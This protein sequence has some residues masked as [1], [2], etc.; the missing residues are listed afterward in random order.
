MDLSKFDTSKKSEQG[1]DLI[2]LDPSTGEQTDMIIKLVGTDSS[3]YRNK[4]KEQAER[5]LQA[6]KKNTKTIDI[7]KA[8]RDSCEM[9]AACTIS[10]QNVSEG[11]EAVEFNQANAQSLYLRHRWLREQVEAFVQDRTHFFPK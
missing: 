4:L 9:L 1:S 2:V 11:K 6:G 7:D 3:R 8:E 5:R 10:W